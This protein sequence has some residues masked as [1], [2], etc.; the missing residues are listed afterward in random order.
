MNTFVDFE[1]VIAEQCPAPTCLSTSTAIEDF[2]NL[3]LVDILDND[4]RAEVS[5]DGEPQFSMEVDDGIVKVENFQ[6]V[7]ILYADSH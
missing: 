7:G 6:L 2:G 3:A 1:N 4:Q 5:Q